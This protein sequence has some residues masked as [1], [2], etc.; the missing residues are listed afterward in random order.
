MTSVLKVHLDV[1]NIY[2]HTK[3]E[4][5]SHGSSKVVA[6]TDRQTDRKTHT[7]TETRLKLLPIR[8]HGW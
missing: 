2:Q 5:P 8:M 7:H 3:N 6:Q 4:V 1:V